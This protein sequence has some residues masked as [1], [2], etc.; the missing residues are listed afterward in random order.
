MY[1]GVK[2]E[3]TRKAKVMM[4]TKKG[5]IVE[6]RGKVRGKEIINYVLGMDQE[7][8][9]L[10]HRRINDTT[11]GDTQA[12][13][14]T[15]QANTKDALNKKDLHYKGK[16][17]EDTGRIYSKNFHRQ[18]EEYC[19]EKRTGVDQTYI[20]DGRVLFKEMYKSNDFRP[21]MLEEM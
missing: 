2:T 3:I 11:T 9:S 16:R 1:A 10:V 5:E 19:Y 15:E 8:T 12:S 17:K 7:L 18:V 4:T 14:K 13:I 20:I 21:V 6:D